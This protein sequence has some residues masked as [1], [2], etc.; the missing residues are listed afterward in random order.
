MTTVNVTTAD[1]TA[2]VTTA[3]V[4]TANV[5]MAN[6]SHIYTYDRAQNVLNFV[7]PHQKLIL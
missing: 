1:C 6:M 5:T 3:N 7:Q 2:D 4:S